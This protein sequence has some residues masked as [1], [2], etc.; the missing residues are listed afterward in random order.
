[1][2]ESAVNDTGAGDGSDG[3]SEDDDEKVENY[4]NT[5]KIVQDLYR[6]YENNSFDSQSFCLFLNLS[7]CL[8]G[9]DSQSFCMILNLSVLF[10]F[11]TFLYSLNSQSFCIF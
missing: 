11:S 4:G 2:S 5:M 8:C 10:R 9:L 7:V 6:I 1:M 3:D